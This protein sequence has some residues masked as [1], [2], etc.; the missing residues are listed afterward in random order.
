MKERVNVLIDLEN[1]DED[2]DKKILSEIKEKDLPVVIL[3]GDIAQHVKKKL[4]KYGIRD[5]HTAVSEGYGGGSTPTMIDEK[6]DRYILVPAF[7]EAYLSDLN[8]SEFRNKEKIYFLADIYDEVEPIEREFYI[9]HG[10]E[11]ENA[12]ERL[13]DDKSKRSMAAFLKAKL[14]GD[15]SDFRSLI[16]MP[17]YFSGDFIKLQNDEVLVDCGA[18]NGDSIRD[19]LDKTKG[20]Y[21]LIYAF[22]PDPQNVSGL[23]CFVHEHGLQ[24]VEILPYGT[25]DRVTELYFQSNAGV[26]SKI[27]DDHG[28]VI[29]T[30][31]IDNVLNSNRVSFIKMDIEGAEI[32]A[33][34]GG[35]KSIERYR[36]ILAISAYH[37]AEDIYTIINTIEQMVHGY[38]FYF[39]LHKV[40]AVDA[41]IYA[42]PIE[43]CIC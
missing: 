3:G 13:E 19:F 31:T 12:Y 37:K 27:D 8:Y 35:R 10:S 41:I 24:N 40:L 11:F 4:E 39:R 25:Y 2:I 36:P 43:R 5:I 20:R 17:Q 21:D 28:T 22:E 15:V 30:E 38:R 29:Q 7:A 16:E 9:L 33:L 18:Y 42:V 34:S 32:K 14:T 26:Y 6:L 23:R 1:L